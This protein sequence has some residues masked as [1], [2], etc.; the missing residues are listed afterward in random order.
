MPG[1]RLLPRLVAPMPPPPLLAAQSSTESPHTEPPPH[2]DA[3]SEAF[4][5]VP[6]RRRRLAEALHRLLALP[7]IPIDAPRPVPTC[8]GE[9]AAAIIIECAATAGAPHP[10]ALAAPAA[11]AAAPWPPSDASSDATSDSRPFVR[12]SVRP[13]G[14]AWSSMGRQ[15]APWSEGGAAAQ[16]PMPMV[17]P[18]DAPA[19]APGASPMP[20]PPPSTSPPVADSLR[21][22]A[23]DRP[24]DCTVLRSSSHAADVAAGGA[25]VAAEAARAAATSSGGIP[26]GSAPP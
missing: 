2:R 24:T 7:G 4:A 14:E 1:P 17:A 9:A 22:S 23:P 12:P 11:T 3:V 18:R 19:A 13:S 10:A 8:S 20:A 15:L 16:P 5:S 25:A 21:G 6:T 26:G